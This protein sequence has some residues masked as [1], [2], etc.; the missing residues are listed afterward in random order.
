MQVSI[1]FNLMYSVNFDFEDHI[2]LQMIYYMLN[3]EGISF[4]IIDFPAMPINYD[5]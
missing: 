3:G 4:G 1:C 5:L 2:I